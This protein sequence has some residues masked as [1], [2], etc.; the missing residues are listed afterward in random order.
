MGCVGDACVREGLWFPILLACLPFGE[1]HHLIGAYWVA[2]CVLLW[3]IRALRRH[4]RRR[5]AVAKA[6]RDV[7][8][9][10][11]GDVENGD[12]VPMPQRMELDGNDAE[13]EA[14]RTV[15]ETERRMQLWRERAPPADEAERF[16]ITVSSVT[17]SAQ[18]EVTEHLTIA[19]LKL[20]V[21]SR[22]GTA[23]DEQCLRLNDTL[24][25]DD[26]LTLGACEFGRE[27]LVQMTAQDA[28]QAAARRERRQQARRKLAAKQRAD[29]GLQA[30]K[31]AAVAEA[32]QKLEAARN[33]RG[34]ISA[35]DIEGFW[36][37]VAIVIP[38]ISCLRATDADS[39][40]K[41]LMVG[42]VPFHRTYRRSNIN[43]S[44]NSSFNN[45]EWYDDHDRNRGGESRH[46][47]CTSRTQCNKAIPFTC[48]WRLC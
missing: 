1:L 30:A 18:L 26:T 17:S 19:E 40:G 46:W 29:E 41:C 42:P 38:W 5:S 47:Y 12:L 36:M 23:P 32:V 7:E 8:L 48:G 20:Q 3:W 39:Y 2:F 13:A 16:S 43:S 11:M 24:L 44:S 10:Q 35:H 33:G 37:G 27:A 15:A 28:A 9:E 4:C 45:F 21:Q 6:V 34:S 31:E 25:D 22:L 14:E